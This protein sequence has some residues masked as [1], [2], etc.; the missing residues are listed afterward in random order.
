[1]TMRVC[2]Y[3]NLIELLAATVLDLLPFLR[4]RGDD[5]LQAELPRERR[6]PVGPHGPALLR[7]R[8]G[9]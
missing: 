1:M 2:E 5:L 4:S 9:L 3:F 6:V 8:R 7:L